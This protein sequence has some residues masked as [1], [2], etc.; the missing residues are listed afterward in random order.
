MQLAP[1]RD[2]DRLAAVERTVGDV[3]DALQLSRNNFDET[4]DTLDEVS[5][6]VNAAVGDAE[7]AKKRSRDA[8]RQAGS[9]LAL[10]GEAKAAVDSI[11]TAGETAAGKAETASRAATEA[12]DAAAKAGAASS[13]AHDAAKKADDAVSSLRKPGTDEFTTFAE[14]LLAHLVPWCVK[15]KRWLFILLGFSVFA[16]AVL[17]AFILY[18]LVWSGEESN[19]SPVSASS[20]SSSTSSA[21]TRTEPAADLAEVSG[22]LIRALIK[23]MRSNVSVTFFA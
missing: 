3:H 2:A 14:Q 21:T 16:Q 13:K 23:P 4:R 9:A 5:K 19:C 6:R 12:E 1:A 22:K 7:G 15:N 20:T 18:R 17:N 8:E 11:K 10:A